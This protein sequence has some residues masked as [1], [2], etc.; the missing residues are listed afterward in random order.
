MRLLNPILENFFKDEA[1][2]KKVITVIIPSF[3]IQSL[4]V[5][6][7]F[8]ISIILAH[9]LGVSDYGVFTY[10]FS[11]VFL[12]VNLSSAGLNILVVRET[13]SLLA[14]GKIQLLSG[15]FRWSTLIVLTACIVLA[16]VLCVLTYY[17]HIMPD[18]SYTAP[19][20]LAAISI[21]FYGLLSFYTSFLRGINKIVFSLVSESIVK[22]ITFFVAIVAIYFFVKKMAL[23]DIIYINTITFVIS[24]L[25]GLVIL[26]RSIALKNETAYDTKVWWGKLGSLFLLNGLLGIESRID[27]IMLG[28]MKDPSQVGIFSAV[29]K[30]AAFLSFFLMTMNFIIAPIISKW[31]TLSEKQQLQKMITKSIRWVMLLSLPLFIVIVVF[32]KP[33]L[34]FFFGKDFEQGQSA[35]IIL[36]CAYLVSIMFG[37]VGNIMTM[38]GNEK[39]YTIFTFCSIVITVILN[40]ILIPSMGYNGAAIATASSIVFWNTGLYIVTKRKLGISAWIFG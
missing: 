14:A 31:N 3:I 1:E 26:K 9:G 28:Y 21:P 38:T 16:I 25:A 10:V 24:A 8:G 5:L 19:M 23:I 11:I 30:I 36:S 40:F 15:F 4:S 12:V 7:S 27:M 17:C 18:E 33:I 2:R 32:S 13:S 6:L 20:L 34:Y 29:G 37:P 35:L 39:Y 22:H